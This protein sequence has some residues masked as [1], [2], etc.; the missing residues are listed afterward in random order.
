MLVRERPP[1]GKKIREI[2]EAAGMTQ[3]NLAERLKELGY[4]P[5]GTRAKN[6]DKQT[7]YRFE[8][9]DHLVNAA[10]IRLLMIIFDRKANDF[11]GDGKK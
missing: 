1:A 8:H 10:L 7:V 4:R 11:I 2:R 5:P 9:N 6:I 3:A